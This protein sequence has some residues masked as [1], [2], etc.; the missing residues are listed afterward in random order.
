MAQDQ[1]GT[2]LSIGAGTI[3][4]SYIV[5]SAVEKA[6]NVDFEDIL[7]ENGDIKTRIVYSKHEKLHLELI[8]LTGALPEN[9]FVEGTIAAHA[10]FT[11]FFVEAA[12][13]SRSKS[14]KRVSV[15][16]VNIGVT[17]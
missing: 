2:D 3:T 10:D 8:C 13:I 7:D 9:D 4:G 17:A 12:P 15:D 11:D 16:L 1:I 14:A 5:E 6:Y